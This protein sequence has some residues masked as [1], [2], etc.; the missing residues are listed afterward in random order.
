M[1]YLFKDTTKWE[2]SLLN[3][4]PEQVHIRYLKIILGLHKSAVNVAVLSETGRFPLAI[5]ATKNT[6]RFWHHLVTQ[7]SNSLAKNAYDYSLDANTGICY[8]LQLILNLLNFNHVWENQ[9]TPSINGLSRALLSK[10]KDRY[11]KYWKSCLTEG[12]FNYMSKLRS[13]KVIKE[14]YK[15]ETYLLTDV[16][17]KFVSYF[18]K[19]RISN[20]KL[21]IEEGRHH[22]VPIEIRI[23]PLCKNDIENELHFLMECNQLHDL[24]QKLFENLTEIVPAFANMNTDDK[25]KFIMSSNDYDINKACVNG[26]GNMYEKRLEY[27]NEKQ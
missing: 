2:S 4:L 8:K 26:I 15:L 17:K 18:T 3:F 10:L 12:N 11:Q 1:D 20:S 19:L 6:L 27:S 22:N 13:Y 24:R 14:E 7:T 25:F 9:N 5:Y 21:M 16:D 23:C